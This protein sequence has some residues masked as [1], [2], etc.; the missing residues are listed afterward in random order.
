MPQAETYTPE[1]LDEVAALLL[2]A[3]Q[4]PRPRVCGATLLVH[5]EGA[6]GPAP[7][8][9]DLA[10]T[11][12]APRF[13]REPE[14]VYAQLVYAAHA[15]DVTDVMVNGRWIVREGRSLTLDRRAIAGKAGEF[16]TRIAASVG[17]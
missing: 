5:A 2:A 10:R 14:G 1:T 8:L 9:V 6:A 3:E 16:R 13:R 7:I 11:H 17:K 15:N 12:N 4:Q